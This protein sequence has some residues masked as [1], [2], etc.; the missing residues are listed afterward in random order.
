[1]KKSRTAVLRYAGRNRTAGWAL[2][3]AIESQRAVV[4]ARPA[5]F[6]TARSSR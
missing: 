2:A 4:N 6:A 1:V 5:R 3:P